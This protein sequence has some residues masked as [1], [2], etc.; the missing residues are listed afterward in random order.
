MTKL[1]IFEFHSNCNASEYKC[2]SEI[3]MVFVPGGSKS[4]IFWTS[5]RELNKLSCQS[6]R[7]NSLKGKTS[8][9]LIDGEKI[10]Y[11]VM[12]TGPLANT[13]TLSGHFGCYKTMSNYYILGKEKLNKILAGKN[14]HAANRYL[15]FYRILA[16]FWSVKSW[17]LKYKYSA[18]KNRSHILF[19]IL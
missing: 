17:S 16:I 7:I 10:C 14:V 8:S 2:R 11:N 18:Q 13:K 4:L 6:N 1:S 3:T 15:Q 19:E 12:V 9:N 5:F